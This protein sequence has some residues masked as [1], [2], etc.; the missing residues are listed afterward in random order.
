MSEREQIS[1]FDDDYEPEQA[2]ARRSDPDTSHDAAAQVNPNLR[3]WQVMDCVAEAVEG[4]TIKETCIASDLPECS[5]SPRFRPL[6]EK[7]MIVRGEKRQNPEGGRMAYV[8]RITP[9]GLAYLEA[10]PTPPSPA[11]DDEEE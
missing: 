2:F 3:E 11:D 4:W 10:H 9:K 1:C 7:G 8:H 5:I 6:I